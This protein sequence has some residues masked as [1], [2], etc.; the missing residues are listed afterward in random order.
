M[1]QDTQWFREGQESNEG[2]MRKRHDRARSIVQTHEA[3]DPR[4][5]L[6]SFVLDVLAI[7]LGIGLAQVV[8]WGIGG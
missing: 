7:A 4:R 2:P 6:V 1:E 3:P 8:T 5:A